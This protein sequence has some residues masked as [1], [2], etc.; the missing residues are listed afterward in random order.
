MANTTRKTGGHFLARKSALAIARQKM[1]RF[2]NFLVVEDNTLEA[3]RLKATLHS[4]F[5][6]EIVVRHAPTLGTALDRVIERKPDIVFLD[7]HLKPA[8]NAGDLIPM[9]RRCEYLGPIIVVS[10]MLNRQRAATLVAAGAALAIHKDNL[11]SGSIAEALAQIYA[12]THPVAEAVAESTSAAQPD[13]QPPPNDKPPA[14]Q[15]ATQIA[16][17]KPTA[18][19]KRKSSAAPN[20]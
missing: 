6:Y 19:A 15:D 20:K 8:D 2:T 12:K 1:P 18:K 13:A 3:D 5:G 17:D 11:D 10:G 14:H 16:A 9:L 4:I 7:D